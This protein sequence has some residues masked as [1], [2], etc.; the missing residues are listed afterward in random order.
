MSFKE[1]ERKEVS[2]SYR[3]IIK[4]DILQACERSTRQPNYVYGDINAF[5]FIKFHILNWI[6]RVL[7]FLKQ[8]VISARAAIH[9]LCILQHHVYVS[10]MLYQQSSSLSISNIYICPVI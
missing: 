7:V 1:L 3:K 4:L 6:A 8:V 9:L 10:S 2:K 5:F